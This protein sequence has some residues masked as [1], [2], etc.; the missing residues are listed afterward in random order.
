MLDKM[1]MLNMLL[2]L[3]I[4]FYFHNNIWGYVC[5]AGPFQCRWLRGYIYSSC[6][7]HHQIGSI[8][9]SHYY[10][11]FRGCVPEMFITPYSVTFC[12]QIPEGPGICFHYYCA[13]YDECKY[14]DAF[15]LA[16]R[17]R[18]FVQCTN[19]H[20]H[21]CA[22]LSEDIELIKCLS[23]IFCRVCE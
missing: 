23:D 1:D 11:I 17:V 19:L 2:V 7:Y 4:T 22:N 16:S 14:L 18:L 10:H 12:I 9:L 6:Y 5:S 3:S 21:L 8:H 20:Y 15:W 13:I